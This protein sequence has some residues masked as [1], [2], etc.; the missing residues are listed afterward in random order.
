MS[1][2]DTIRSDSGLALG[3]V[4]FAATMMVMGGVFQALQGLAA[5]LND[6][7]FIVGPEYT[8]SLDITAWG[9]L[10]LGFGI[11]ILLS[12]I[13][14]F[15]GSGVAGLVAMVLATLGAISNFVF[16]PYYPVWSLVL[17]AINIFVIWAITRADILSSD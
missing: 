13:Y 8:Y 3:G 15:S 4:V 11:L 14:L 16:I 1:Q 2:H 7:I 5:I 12:G 10:H 17:I 9:W 6:K